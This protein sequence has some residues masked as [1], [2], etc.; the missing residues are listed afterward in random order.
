MATRFLLEE[1]H[2]NCLFG[3]CFLSASSGSYSEVVASHQTIEDVIVVVA[4]L[5][6][7]RSEAR[8]VFA[9]T[10]SDDRDRLAV[11]T[12]RLHAPSISRSR[13]ELTSAP[14]SYDGSDGTQR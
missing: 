7:C 3:A 14:L 8:I 12:Y 2:I 9:C 4:D 10:L 11:N 5:L 6:N 1:I 13:G